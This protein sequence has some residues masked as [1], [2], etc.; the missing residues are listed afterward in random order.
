M[1]KVIKL[2]NVVVSIAIGW[3]IRRDSFILVEASKF[4]DDHKPVSWA[5]RCG[6][7]V[8]SKESGEFN[9]EK[10]PSGRDEG[11]YQEYRFSSD[12]EAIECWQKHHIESEIFDPY[13]QI[14]VFAEHG[15]EAKWW[16]PATYKCRAM[17]STGH[18]VVYNDNNQLD[19]VI[20]ISHLK[21]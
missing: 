4:D 13:D 7:R 14:E 1:E 10:M 12:K 15:K 8:L 19:E 21:K 20:K 3:D 18:M 6:S 16:R 9:Y 11:F 2:N 5:V 17:Q